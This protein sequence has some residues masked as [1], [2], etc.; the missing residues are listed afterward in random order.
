[1][2]YLGGH[3]ETH[4]GVKLNIDSDFI[5][6]ATAAYGGGIFRLPGSITKP[7]L[8]VRP[9]PDGTV[10]VTSRWAGEPGITHFQILGGNSAT[11]LTVVKTVSAAGNA[12]VVLS[13]V[14]NYFEVEGLNASGAAV[15]VSNPVQTPQ[16]VAIY[17]GS[18]Y[19]AASGPVGIRCAA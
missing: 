7:T 15:G 6:A 18:A 16:S 11:T 5:D 4:G 10:S 14:Y 9:Q 2:Q 1:M 3:D 13:D 17:G 19:V 8:T 12:A